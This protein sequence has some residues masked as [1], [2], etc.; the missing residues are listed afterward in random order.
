MTIEPVHRIYKI[1]MS[2]WISM[3]ANELEID[4]VGLWQIIPC[5]RED[6]SLDESDLVDFVQRC[7][8]SLLERGAKPV[9]GG[10]KKGDYPWIVQ[11]HYGETNEEIAEN[12]INEWSGWSFA[13]P[14]LGGI[15]FATPKIY[16][17]T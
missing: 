9:L 11:Y 12:I 13:D 17:S 6:F 4:A 10:G 15:W 1:P 5:G 7:I 3:M 2:D 8:I 14:S 16:E